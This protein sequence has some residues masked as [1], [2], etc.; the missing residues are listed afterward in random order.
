MLVKR[1]IVEYEP[2]KCEK[3]G[4]EMTIKSMQ[5]INKKKQKKEDEE[6]NE[7]PSEYKFKCAICGKQVIKREIELKAKSIKEI[8]EI[9]PD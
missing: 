3:C 7:K 5:T 9:E 2:I 8:V 1:I 6:K 4:S